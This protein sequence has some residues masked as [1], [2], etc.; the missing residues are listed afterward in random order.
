MLRSSLWILFS[1]FLFAVMAV[2]TKYATASLTVWEI[3]FFRSLCGV[4]L[5]A[6]VMHRR[7]IPFA[8]PHPWRF[9]LRCVLGTTGITLGVFAIKL[10]PL[11]TAQTFNYAS[12]LWF[13]LFL[14]LAA[15]M[16]GERLE[17]PLLAAVAAGF[18]GVLIILRP[19][20]PAGTAAGAV[21]GI[22]TGIFS[23]AADF[24]IRDLSQRREPAERIV[25]WFALTGTVTGLAV[26]AAT[27]FSEVTLENALLL[28]GIGVT[29]ALALLVFTIGWT[30]GHPL[31]NAVFQ[32]TGIPF[33]V[34]F[35]LILFG[36]M[37]DGIAFIGIALV[38][39]AGLAASLVRMKSEK[40]AA[41]AAASR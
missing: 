40:R 12:P 29:G 37:P 32:F 14:S 1:T 13:C 2:F 25:F 3:L 9:L 38:A 34:L 20:L 7:R 35:G 4:I 24:M 10:L 22:L 41:K 6:A 18:A 36:E 19:D 15:A 26:S 27:G 16:K 11:A 28:F 5:C 30:K 33:A 17:R 39:L 21:I 8:T 23:G 31:L